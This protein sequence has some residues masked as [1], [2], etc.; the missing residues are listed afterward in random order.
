[1]NIFRGSVVKKT[2]QLRRKRDKGFFT[3]GLFVGAVLMGIAAKL[4]GK[5]KCRKCIKRMLAE[6]K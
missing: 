3:V 5:C 1:M 4:L 6:K 2:R